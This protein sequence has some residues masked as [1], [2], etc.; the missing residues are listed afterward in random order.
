LDLKKKYGCKVTDTD[1][2]YLAIDA[3]REK[4]CYNDLLL[5]D[6]DKNPITREIESEQFDYILY[7]DIL[8]HLKN[9]WHVLNLRRK[10]FAASGL[11]IV[12]L[13]N[14]SNSRQQRVG[15]FQ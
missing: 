15:C 4:N 13:L 1:I 12:S 10:L 3:A 7:L 6:L 9:L 14:V 8:E 5:C 11:V 2:S